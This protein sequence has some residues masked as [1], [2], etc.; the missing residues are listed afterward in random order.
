MAG[1]VLDSY[2]LLSYLRDEEGADVVQAVLEHAE[3]SGHNVLMCEVNYAEVQY[4]IRRKH[5]AGEWERVAEVLRGLP[6]GFVVADRELS[7]LAAQ[8]KALHRMSLADA[9]AAALAQ[10]SKAELLT[11][12]EEFKAVEDEITVRWLR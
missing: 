1:Y 10:K 4:M 12:D 3:R 9:Y 7:N 5:G 6:I 2:A 11:G 8:F